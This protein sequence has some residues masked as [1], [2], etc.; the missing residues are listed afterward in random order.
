MHSH[1]YTGNPLACSIACESLNIFRDENVLENNR[2]KARLIGE[3]AGAMAA[4]HPHVGEF[5][6]LGMVGALELVEDKAS[7]KPFDWKKRVGYQIYQIALKRGLLLRPLGNVIYF[8]P[9]YVIG[10]AEIEWMISGAFRAID[11]Y[12]NLL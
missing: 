5:R 12:F 8:M 10:E 7:K 11:Q 2:A 3:L 1:S 6:Q 9:P 4:R